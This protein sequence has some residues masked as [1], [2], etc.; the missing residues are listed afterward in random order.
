MTFFFLN[1]LSHAFQVTQHFGD[2]NRAFVPSARVERRSKLLSQRLALPSRRGG[3]LCHSKSSCS[4]SPPA[5]PSQAHDY[6]CTSPSSPA[7]VTKQQDQT[8]KTL[9]RAA[10]PQNFP[11]QM[12]PVE[13]SRLAYQSPSKMRW[14]AATI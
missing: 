6:H 1:A 10:R 11:L 13:T 3:T 4:L 8:N 7:P 5:L 9:L 14:S 12:H 2:C